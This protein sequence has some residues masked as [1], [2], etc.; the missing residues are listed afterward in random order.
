M[1]DG[2]V[3]LPG[4]LC[5]SELW[6]GV[7]SDLTRR[8]VAAD[9]RIPDLTGQRS[10]EEMA[11]CV[12]ATAPRRFDLIGFSMGGYVAQRVVLLAPER[13]RRLALIDTSARAD[14]AEQSSRRRELVALAARSGIEA[15][16]KRLLP[17][18]LAPGRRDGELAARIVRMAGRVGFAAFTRQQQAIMA[19]P[20]LRE[21]LAAFACPTLVVCGALDALTPL[22][23]SEELAELI[24][25]AELRVMPRAGHM[26]PLEEPVALG[27]AVADFLSMPLE[28]KR[29]TLA[30]EP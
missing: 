18:F 22:R 15:A 17:H 21:D 12:L 29:K 23:L 2:L 3:F 14:T 8:R 26:T 30:V 24:P 1:S 9:R 5:D 25:G 10:I 27:A 13:V 16:A 7:V 4:L 19:R 28:T 6:E 20:D 11:R